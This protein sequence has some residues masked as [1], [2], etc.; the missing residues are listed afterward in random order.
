MTDKTP[1]LSI[2][3]VN[4]NTRD[5][6][7]RCLESIDSGLGCVQAEVFVVDNASVDGSADM[8]RDR[9]PHVRLIENDANLGFAAANNLVFERAAGR[10]VL[11]LNPDTQVHPDALERIVDYLDRHERV[12]A[13]GAH[14]LN[15]DGTTQRSVRD[16]PTFSSA[17]YQYTL[18]RLW[19]FLKKALRRYK[20]RD[21]DYAVT[22]KVP[23]PMGAALA[24][25][26][27]VLRQVGPMDTDFFMYYEEADL[28]KRIIAGGW[29][30]HYLAE[31]H[32]TH[33]SGASARQ[34]KPSLFLQEKKSLLRFFD[35]HCGRTRTMLFR[36]VFKPLFIMKALFDIPVDLVSSLTNAAKG[37]EY[38]AM[39]KRQNA[40]MKAVFLLRDLPKFLIL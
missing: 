16:F 20:M 39:R 13:V 11:L 29:E 3:I 7:A 4:W 36:L 5:H 32:V 35:K 19:P 6:L 34:V 37:R 23:Q 25:R 8:V 27:E 24:V 33:Y 18:L 28:C 9:Y 17:L 38:Q 26:K 14:L 15:E 22:Q 30:I 2:A 12:G 40:R 21:F 31:A 1:D 10:F